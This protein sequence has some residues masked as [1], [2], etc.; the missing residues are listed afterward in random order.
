MILAILHLYVTVMP[1]HCDVSH[2]VSAQYDLR[3]GRRFRLKNFMIAPM[4]VNLGYQNGMILAILY[5]Y[6]APMLPMKFR[7]NLTYSLGGDVV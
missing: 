7:L 2:Q 3:F 6:V 4:A 1:R 5:L